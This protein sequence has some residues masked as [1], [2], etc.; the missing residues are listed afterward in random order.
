MKSSFTG[1]YAGF[2]SFSVQ[3]SLEN[4][5]SENVLSFFLSYKIAQR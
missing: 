4:K 1:N 2:G 3:L 5:N